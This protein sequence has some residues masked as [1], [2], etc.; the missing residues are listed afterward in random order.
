[1]FSWI[2]ILAIK[3][4]D[5]V[6]KISD[7][8]DKFMR[9]V[10]PPPNQMLLKDKALSFETDYMARFF[11]SSTS[12][13]QYMIPWN[14]GDQSLWHGI[15][16]T[17]WAFRNKV[18]GDG[19]M[20]A[21]CIDG[22]T[23]HQPNGFLMRGKVGDKVEWSTSN[24]Q[25]SG[26]LAGLFFTGQKDLCHQWT[27][28]IIDHKYAMT[29]P[30]GTVTKF[31]QLEN[32]ILT[33]PLRLT[34]LLAILKYA[35]EDA[36]YK[37]LLSKYGALAQYPKVRLATIGKSYDT[38][39]AAI[40]LSILNDLD[41]GCS[42]YKDGLKR[43]VPEA[44]ADGNVWVML[45]AARAGISVDVE[46]VKKVLWEFDTITRLQGNIERLNS[47][48]AALWESRGIKFK[49]W[50]GEL[51]ATQPLPRWVCGSQDFY[52][53]RNLRSVDNHAGHTGAADTFHSGVDFL[54]CYWLAR[55]LGMIT[56][57]E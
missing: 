50:N 17:M 13:F 52:W 55:N 51:Q 54:V 5:V 48:D 21:A 1:M 28:Q 16:S 49:Q 46:I 40:H 47:K 6:N 3:L 57:N 53:Q 14:T 36:H 12:F 42:Y 11:D 38:H 22:L 45:L 19:K 27:A 33:D 35:G 34:L 4:A 39:R 10:F 43:M 32:G 9:P 7:P 31:G 26:H 30:D 25:A 44:T 29:E 23:K 24:D 56:E 41:P 8:W 15:A 18:V 37:K 2:K 20:V